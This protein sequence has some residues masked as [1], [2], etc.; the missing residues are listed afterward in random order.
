MSVQVATRHWQMQ[1][2]MAASDAAGYDAAGSD[3]IDVSGT[4]DDELA[5][6]MGGRD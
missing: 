1:R 6:A 3:E 2:R 5:A 4:S